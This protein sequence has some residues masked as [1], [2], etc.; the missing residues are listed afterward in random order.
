MNELEKLQEAIRT[1]F[2]AAIVR[3][4]PK[5]LGRHFGWLDVEYG[6]RS[7]AVEWRAGKGF[8]VSGL[9]EHPSAASEGLFEGPDQVFPDL[10]P[11]KEHIFVLLE[12]AEEASRKRAR[13]VALA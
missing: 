3:I 4:D 6:G 13:R 2:P 9:P 10:G 12:D 7:F 8:G 11:A 5:A 1:E